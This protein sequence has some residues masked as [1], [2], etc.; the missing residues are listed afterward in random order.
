VSELRGKGVIGA[1][2][3]VSGAGT[4]AGG[5]CKASGMEVL[6]VLKL[7][8]STSVGDHMSELLSLAAEDV[9]DVGDC[10]KRKG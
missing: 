8:E 4:G 1:G 7:M 5:V 10:E 9:R 2:K 6:G 3:G